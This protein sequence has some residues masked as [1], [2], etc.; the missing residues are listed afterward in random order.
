ML[1]LSRKTGDEIVMGHGEIRISVLEI[2][3]KRVQLG[4][5]AP[6]EVSI[7]RHEVHQRIVCE[8]VSETEL[9]GHHAESSEATSTKT[10]R[11]S[12]QINPLG[13]RGRGRG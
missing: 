10:S 2:S 4:I 7:R 11:R 13:R 3:G 6:T 5:S 1:V 12:P 8:A 9:Q